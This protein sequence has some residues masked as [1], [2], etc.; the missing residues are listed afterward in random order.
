[1]AKQTI[2][3][4]SIT[5]NPRYLITFDTAM[6]LL[7]EVYDHITN[8]K[9]DHSIPIDD[10]YLTKLSKH[11]SRKKQEIGA[12]KKDAKKNTSDMNKLTKIETLCNLV[13]GICSLK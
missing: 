1:M 4:K 3:D 13:A 10:K 9:N 8:K 2:S 6:V 5:T 11:V 12:T 7:Q